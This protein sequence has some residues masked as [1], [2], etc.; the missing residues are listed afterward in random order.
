MDSNDAPEADV[1]EQAAE[2]VSQPTPAPPTVE[3]DVP[4]ADAVEQAVPVVLEPDALPVIA[5]EP[6]TELEDLPVLDAPV[7]PDGAPEPESAAAEPV[8]PVA[9]PPVKKRRRAAVRPAGS[10]TA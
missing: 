3:Q 1:A 10:P 4:E 6:P 9:D 2:V 7:T 5:D 8:E